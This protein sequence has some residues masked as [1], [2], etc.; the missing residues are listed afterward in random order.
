MTET[1]LNVTEIT[2]GRYGV[3]LDDLKARTRLEELRGKSGFAEALKREMEKAEG[4]DSKEA[5][6]KKLLDASYEL[7]SFFIGYMLKAMRRT[8]DESDFTGRSIAKD[9]FRDMLYDE[10]A[11]VMARTDQLGLARQIYNQ[12]RGQISL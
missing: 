1:L 9:I 11:K 5:V 12:L 2:A 6:Q 4:Q 3:L 8:L 7:E 10:Y